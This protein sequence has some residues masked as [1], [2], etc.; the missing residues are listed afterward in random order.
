MAMAALPPLPS[1]QALDALE[2]LGSVQAAADA[3]SVT[4]SAVSHRL[5]TLEE[6]AGFPLAAP[7]GRGVVVTP[8]ARALLAATR[9]ALAALS[10][11]FAA[12]H[13]APAAG[14][15]RVAA[16]PGFASAWLCPR[17]AAFRRANPQILMT[18]AV[19][20]DPAADAEILFAHPADAPRAERLVR[21]AFFPVCAPAIAHAR[22]GLH[23]LSALAGQTFLHLFD[24]RDWAAWAGAAG[25]PEAMLRDAAASGR[26]VIF[27]D[28]NM[29][30][31]A[32][33][34]GQGVALGDPITCERL[35]ADGAL[36]RPFAATSESERAYFLRLRRDAAPAA[37]A[38]AAWL[39]AELPS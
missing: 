16:P 22:K 27:E 5:R 13:A 24:R 8:R 37:E 1:L 2:R 14:P 30:L 17:L 21:P 6:A 29:L 20:D 3:L 9:P 26:E 4:A 7:S 31:A 10:E 36:A 33:L 34:S 39:R 28:A 38:F 32:A 19:G 11:A 23:S 35:L 25:A 12:A 18:L 15:L